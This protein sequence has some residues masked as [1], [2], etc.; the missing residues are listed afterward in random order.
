MTGCSGADDLGG[1]MEFKRITDWAEVSDCGRYTVSA[2]RV[3]GKYMFQGWR[4]SKPMAVLLGTRQTAQAARNLCIRD[5]DN[6]QE[7]AI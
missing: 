3:S 7:E 4:R 5:S 2:A 1:A 6:P